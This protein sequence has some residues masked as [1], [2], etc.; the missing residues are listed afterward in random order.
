MGIANGTGKGKVSITNAYTTG[1]IWAGNQNGDN[2]Y[3]EDTSNFVRSIWGRKEGSAGDVQIENTYYIRPDKENN[4]PFTDLSEDGRNNSNKA[5]D[6]ADKDN[7]EAYQ[8]TENNQTHHLGESED[9]PDGSMTNP[10]LDGGNGA[11]VDES[12]AWRIYEGSTPILNAFLPNTEGYFSENGLQDSV[13]NTGFDV[14]YGT[15]YDPLLTIINANGGKANLEFNWIDLGANNAAGIAVYGA[16]LTLND[17]KATGGSGYYAGLLYADGALSIHAEGDASFGSAAEL[18]GSSVTI[19][20]KGDVT[21]Y[22]DVTA[23]GNIQDG[24]SWDEDAKKYTGTLSEDENNGK[25]NISGGSV[26]ISTASS[27]RRKRTENL[28]ACRESTAWRKDG[29]PLP[30]RMRTGSP[31]KMRMKIRTLP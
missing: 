16:G 12:F 7:A 2:S 23:T 21:I 20:A 26:D 13:G 10:L 17:F 29:I 14:Q 28:F 11:N 5:I 9:Y 1:N 24:T 3:S 25:I 15:A 31:L 30:L 22:G 19:D 6:F 18:Y 8:Y 27:L 4:L